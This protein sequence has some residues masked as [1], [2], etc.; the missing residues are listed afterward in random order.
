LRGHT[1]HQ[2]NDHISRVLSNKR[3]PNSKGALLFKVQVAKRKYKEEEKKLNKEDIKIE[4]KLIST[5]LKLC[6]LLRRSQPIY[7]SGR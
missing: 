1:P 2:R 3:N 5:T 6:Y 4:N 7:L